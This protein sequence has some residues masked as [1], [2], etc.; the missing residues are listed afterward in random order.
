MSN[1][2]D[3]VL[4]GSK[5]KDLDLDD[6]LSDQGL[7]FSWRCTLLNDGRMDVCRDEKGAE[8]SLGQT[9]TL[10]VVA[11]TLL[12]TATHPYFFTLMVSKGTR[13]PSTF[14]VPVTVLNRYVPEVTIS[15]K[16]DH[17]VK[18]DGST[19]INAGDKLILGSAC[20]DA[21]SLTWSILPAVDVS[22]ASMLPMGFSAVS[23]VIKEGA[24]V[25][26]PG[27]I[28]SISLKCT[29]RGSS[30]T[31]RLDLEVNSP[32]Q[33]G[34]C[35]SCL[36]AEGNGCSKT[37]SAIID[38]FV[39]SCSRFA[40]ADA[41][42]GYEFGYKVGDGPEI[43][44]VKTS[45]PSNELRLPSGTIQTLARVV[46]SA[47]AATAVWTDTISVGTS[48]RR[49]FADIDFNAA[50]DLV[51]AKMQTQDASSVNQ[52][53]TTIAVEVA[54]ANP[55]DAKVIIQAL[56]QKLSA[57]Q[58][59][60]VV[61]KEYLCESLQA[62]WAVSETL[63]IQTPSS[64]QEAI[65][66]ISML[67]TGLMQQG[68]GEPLNQACSAL[69]L[70]IAATA[71][72]Y[73]KTHGTDF[74]KTSMSQM[75][76]GVEATMAR[77]SG[78]LAQSETLYLA[79]RT[80]ITSHT[81]QRK[82]I[83]DLSA[84]DLFVT[85]SSSSSRR[86]ST[87]A[88]TARLPV[89]FATAIS[90]E[91]TAPVVAY[92]SISDYVPAMEHTHTAVSPL[93]DF[94]IFNPD[95]TK[96]QVQNVASGIVITLPVDY[97]SAMSAEQKTNRRA[98]LRCVYW[99]T[100]LLS[101]SDKGC[102]LTSTS[103][104][105]ATCSCNHL[106]QI[107]VVDDST[108]KPQSQTQPM[109]SKPNSTYAEET[110]FQSSSGS[111]YM[112]V[113]AIAGGAA[114]VLLVAGS[115]L[116]WMYLSRKKR[117][118]SSVLPI[119]S[120]L[121]ADDDNSDVPYSAHMVFPPQ[122]AAEAEEKEDE[123]E[124][125]HTESP[126]PTVADM[127]VHSTTGRP[128]ASRRPAYES[129]PADDDEEVFFRTEI[130][131][132]RM[133][134]HNE[135][136]ADLVLYVINTP[137]HV[138]EEE[139]EEPG[140]HSTIPTYILRVRVREEE[141]ENEKEEEKGGEEEEEEEE[142]E[143]QQKKVVSRTEEEDTKMDLRDEAI[144]DLAPDMLNKKQ[145]PEAQKDEKDVEKDEHDADMDSHDNDPSDLASDVLKTTQCVEARSHLND[146]KVQLGQLLSSEWLHR[147][148]EEESKAVDQK[149]EMDEKKTPAAAATDP[150]VGSNTETSTASNSKSH[151]GHK[152]CVDYQV[153]KA[154][155]GHTDDVD[156]IVDNFISEE[157]ARKTGQASIF[158]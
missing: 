68:G 15:V 84:S 74:G 72:K 95:M 40:D 17:R 14:S 6:S 108:I 111:A 2:A 140:A 97:T 38:T 92:L 99:D 39:I 115:L 37:G 107:T 30:A 67:N 94:T 54:R 46:D 33:G 118:S 59:F 128:M 96:R 112:L 78:S 34:I 117:R 20:Q 106:T 123:E 79:S 157:E 110:K 48:R 134:S 76:Y 154:F 127:D 132:T 113:P 144:S 156:Q 124:A 133:D 60:A 86:L 19:Q 136:A 109:F 139:E 52:L 63:A 42:L 18:A 12:P 146:L 116:S 93:L 103:E 22:D 89:G 145:H 138:E 102:S 121:A 25:L 98:R 62:C 100:V 71:L 49:L 24:S 77:L 8:L 26:M 153:P 5:S 1:L 151:E 88:V 147:G 44:F 104:S 23:F 47:G 61:N 135:A 9:A 51:T 32:P 45:W 64:L 148:G 120:D 11:G 149:E 75:S 143:Q 114:A 83:T 50:V 141:D 43:W 142:E 131:D 80:G 152:E 56:M 55:T 90:A 82:S 10:T 81:L 66:L 119:S 126:T 27:V 129:A 13:I 28:Y 29:T 3:F 130:N 158:D 155:V 69:A 87:P 36:A 21:S 73:Q 85:S 31:A 105:T 101:Y 16:S 122:A 4:D 70:D 125:E 7:E 137:Q 53:S 65:R 41:P 58:Q 91:A 35:Q 150:V 57:A